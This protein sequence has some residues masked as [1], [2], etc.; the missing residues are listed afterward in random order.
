MATLCSCA[1]Q[2]R[3]QCAPLPRARLTC[4]WEHMCDQW[5]CTSVPS[6]GACT[7][8]P[9]SS[10]LAQQEQ[11]AQWRPCVLLLLL[12]RATSFLCRSGRTSCWARCATSCCTRLGPSWQ[13]GRAQMACTAWPAR[14]ARPAAAAAAAVPTAAAAAAAAKLAAARQAA[15]AQP[16]AVRRA[17]AGGGRCPLMSSCGRRCRQ[18]RCGAVQHCAYLTATAPPH[19]SA[20][21]ARTP[22][23]AALLCCA[24]WLGA[25]GHCA[26]NHR[27]SPVPLPPRS[28]ASCWSASMAT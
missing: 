21:P 16:A 22:H 13:G 11:R 19:I 26:R 6:V 23:A 25:P 4:S 10:R 8:A 18:C 12:R 24:A 20:V 9:A 7:P 15:L 3:M 14:P 5:V 27:C 17:V 1:E 2:H 28:W